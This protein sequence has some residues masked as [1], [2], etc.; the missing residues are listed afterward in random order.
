MN[1]KLNTKV[2]LTTMALVASWTTMAHGRKVFTTQQTFPFNSDGR[3]LE[4]VAKNTIYLTF[5]DG[6]TSVA[7]PT[8]L[9]LLKEYNIKATFFMVGK[10][11]KA[12]QSLVAEIR[13]NGHRVANHS[14]S[15]EL[16]FSDGNDF[17]D[18]LI[19]TN[20]V[21]E[22]YMKD[23]D[24]RL[25]RAPGG[26][27]HDYQAIAANG[28][29]AAKKYVGPIYWN[30]GG[31]NGNEKDDA[32]WKC[33]STWYVTPKRCGKSYIKQ[34]ESNYRNGRASIVLMHDINRKSADMLEYILKKLSKSKVNWKFDLIE[35]IP[36]V[37]KLNQ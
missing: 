4:A 3:T 29:E 17:L 31:G 11:A 34:I 24:I 23:S 36:S 7:T 19:S 5:D 8:I 35:N 21:I 2:M 28:N 10:M 12:H 22:D 16:S 9:D 18:T 20:D 14:Y 6:P 26:N 30:V 27:W 33:W 1:F 25:F 37:K 15:H 32:D 13:A